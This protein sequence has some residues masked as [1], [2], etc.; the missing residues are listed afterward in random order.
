MHFTD[1]QIAEARRRPIES[2]IEQEYELIGG[3]HSRFPRAKQHDSLV[4]D[5]AKNYYIWNSKQETGDPIDWLMRYRHLSFPEAVAFLLD[6]P[7][8]L[9]PRWRAARGMVARDAPATPTSML[10]QELHLAYHHRLGR[11]GLAWWRGRGVYPETVERLFLGEAAY[12]YTIP[13][14]EDGILRDV[15]HRNK[16]PQS[17][18]RY[19]PERAGLGAHLYIPFPEALAQEQVFWVTGEIK[20]MVCNQAGLP[21]LC[22]TAGADSWFRVWADTLRGHDVVLVFD[23]GEIKQAERIHTKMTS[24]GLTVRPPLWL[25]ADI[26]DLLVAHSMSAEEIRRFL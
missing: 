12:S 24:D 10:E 20:V 2:L 16:N 21:A 1:D 4:I 14:F 9:S 25:P 7:D 5:R 13:V 15:R 18:F 22:S 23:P 11:T 3:T 6:L 17:A 19:W 26:D 8:L